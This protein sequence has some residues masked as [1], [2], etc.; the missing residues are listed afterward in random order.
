M[1]VWVAKVNYT[2]RCWVY[3]VPYISL[4][5]TA[6]ITGLQTLA[7]RTTWHARWTLETCLAVYVLVHCRSATWLTKI[8]NSYITYC[9]KY[10][11]ALAQLD[12]G[13]FRHIRFV[14]SLL[15]GWSCYSRY[16]IPP[17]WLGP[18][19]L[20]HCHY[21]DKMNT[22]SR[23]YVWAKLTQVRPNTCREKWRSVFRNYVII[24]MYLR[25]TIGKQ[26]IHQYTYYYLLPIA[27][28]WALGSIAKYSY[29]LCQVVHA[30]T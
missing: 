13:T 11:C 8:Y 12:L 16:S 7:W 9:D 22:I 14:S 2:T 24:Q 19:P 10:V 18:S 4:F 5:L 23:T 26:V 28:E 1:Y 3:C 29:M 25:H 27:N 15:I 20:Y 17:L 30:C 6:W 21:K